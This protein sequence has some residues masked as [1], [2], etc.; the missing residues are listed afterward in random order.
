M[1]FKSYR[2][3]ENIAEKIFANH[4]F[5]PGVIFEIYEEL[6]KLNKKTNQPKNG[7]KIEITSP[8]KLH[9]C[10]ITHP[11]PNAKGTLRTLDARTRAAALSLCQGCAMRCTE[12]PQNPH[13]TQQPRSWVFTP[14][15]RALHTNY[16]QESEI[17]KSIL[18]LLRSINAHED[19]DAP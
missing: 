9:E 10:H 19:S 12:S 14:E 4:L 8:K 2:E 6:S 16:S 5:D 11:S 15:Q 7:Q 18:R 3:G 1:F 17:G 13:R